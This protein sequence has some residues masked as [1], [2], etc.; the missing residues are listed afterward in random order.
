MAI[1]LLPGLLG[2]IALSAGIVW[3]R[4]HVLLAR[5]MAASSL[6]LSVLLVVQILV[7]G[8]DLH[9]QGYLVPDEL[10][11]LLMCMASVLACVVL[12]RARVEDLTGPALATVLISLASTL[13]V[14]SIG[15]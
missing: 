14:C 8:Q 5:A 7:L 15:G 3:I 1:R 9:R 2:S 11:V 12:F 6:I 4:P 10:T 13:G